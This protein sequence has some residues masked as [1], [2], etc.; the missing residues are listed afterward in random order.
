LENLILQKTEGIPFFIEEF[1]KSMKDLGGIESKDN[2]CRLSKD[3]LELTIPSTIHDMIMAR[4][5]TLPEGAREVLRTGSVIE[6][7]FSYDLIKRV[8]GLPDQELLSCISSLKDS[9]LL[10]ERG[11]YPESNYIFKH[12]L[13][14]EVV[15]D[16]ILTKKRKQLHEKIAITMEEVYKDNICDH[17]G[18]VAGHCIASENFEKGAEY[19]RLE[20][21]KYQKAGLFKDA[22]EHQK[23]SISCLER[24]LQTEGNQKKIIDARTTLA[25]YHLT[26]A[27]YSEVRDAVQPVM[28]LALKLNY[29]KRLPGMYTAIG[30]HFIY[31]EEDFLNGIQWINDALRISEELGDILSL[32]FASYHLSNFLL[33]QCEFE[34]ASN[35]LKRCLD[36]SELAN[37]PMG[38]SF[39]KASI[40]LLWSFRGNMPLASKAGEEALQIVEGSGDILSKAWPYYVYGITLYL[41]GAL[42]DAERFLLEGKT[43]S[44]KTSQAFVEMS[45]AA[46]LGSLYFAMGE[47]KKAKDFFT[48]WSLS[49]KGS[50][51]F[52]SLANL[53]KSYLARAQIRNKEL[54]VDLHELF[55]YFENN[56]LKYCEGQMAK[57][58][59][60]VMI[61]MDDDHMADAEIWI[62]KAI[63]ADTRNGTRWDLATDH[64]LYADWFKKRGDL[65]GAKE[66]LIRAIDVFTECG[67]D[68][69]IL[70][71][72]KKLDLLQ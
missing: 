71:Y 6:R 32:W 67:A 12:A 51:I 42:D 18:V 60:D 62:K 43:Y 27:H 28:D 41:R 61:Q 37:N 14:R 2:L 55:G 46:V 7:E 17:Y 66:Q 54:D 16:S 29:R 49:L 22:V 40:S 1:I 23:R 30:L 68:G 39:S 45:T 59:G 5:D 21:K 35:C 56:K 10:Y 36:L 3:I 47:Y 48:I 8:T 15:Y 58:I 52:P 57:N 53:A 33:L 65:L 11:I 25:T 63:E 20:A 69:W 34:K 24:L 13:T 26:L 44:Q 38:I 72:R 4:V 50:R 9:E 31:V 70:K 64:A 19:S